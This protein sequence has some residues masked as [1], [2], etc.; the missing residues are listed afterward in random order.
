MPGN[1]IP[2]CC[3]DEILVS[4][5]QRVSVPSLKVA[6][7]I[8]CGHVNFILSVFHLQAY[9]PHYLRKRF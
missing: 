3:E 7:L 2:K 4:V 1:W 9:F 5:L 8:D 6:T